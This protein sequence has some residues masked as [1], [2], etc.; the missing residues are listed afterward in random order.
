MK[1]IGEKLFLLSLSA[2]L[3]CLLLFATIQTPV[4][5]EQT[6]PNFLLSAS[7]E[8]PFPGETVSI[9]LLPPFN[10]AEFGVRWEWEGGVDNFI[11]KGHDAAAYEARDSAAKISATVWDRISGED[12]SAASLEI[13]PQSYD[14]TIRIV[15]PENIVQLWDKDSMAMV[16]RRGR[17]SRSRVALGAVIEP[18]PGGELR[19]VWTPGE[20]VVQDSEDGSSYVVYRETPGLAVVSLAVFN[21][22]N[23]RLGGAEISF[24]IDISS[25]EQERSIKLNMGWRRWQ[26][27][28]ALRE[29]GEVEDALV[30]ARQAFEELTAGGMRGDTLRGEMDRFRQ[31]HLNYFRALEQASVAASL[32]RDGKLEE[33]LNQYRQARTLYAHT[34]IER[35]IAEIEEFL[36]RT[37]ERRA[38][39][40]A[41]AQEAQQLADVGDLT[42]AL[43]KYS[44]SLVYYPSMEVRAARSRVEGQRN[45]LMRRIGLA[46]MVRQ[47]GLNLEE[48]GNF[49]E[50]LSKMVE[51]EEIWEL[52]ELATDMERLNSRIAERQRIRSE[53]ATMAREASQMEIA[54]LEGQGD[55]ET[56]TAALDKYRQ[57]R[58]LWRDDSIERAIVRVAIHI[59][60]INSEIEQAEFLA[61][62]ADS[63]MQDNRL[64]EALD[65]YLSAQFLRRDDEVA[66]KIAALE[67]LLETRRQLTREA[68]AHYLRAEEL[69]R[70][71]MLD[72]ALAS[73]LLGEEILISNELA[74]DRFSTTVRRLELAIEARNDRIT[75]AANLAEQGRAEPHP[76]RALDFFLESLNT[77]YT[78]EVSQT[79]RIMRGLLHETRSAEAR[80]AELYREAV[81]LG[82]ES[83]LAEAEEKL[84]SSIAL[85][86][87]SEAEALL[88][89]VREKIA[90]QIWL[91]TLTAQPLTLRAIPVIPRVGER[92]TIRIEG[93]AWTT[94]MSLTYLWS[95]SGNAISDAPLHDGRAFG[96]YPAD[97]EP[98]TVT[99]TVLRAGTDQTLATR[100]ISIM[101]E[102]RTVRV[103]MNEGARVARLWNAATRRLEET[104]QI[105]TGTDIEL[106]VDVIPMPE[107][108]V[109]YSWDADEYSVLTISENPGVNRASVRRISPGTTYVE[110]EA[111]D[112]HGILLGTGRISILVAVDQND[113]ARDLRRYQAW[114]IWAEARELWRAN[115]RLPAIE[116]ATEASVLD[117]GDPDITH[118]LSRMKEELGKME[119]ASRLLA[120]SSLLIATGNLDEAAVR[121]SEADILWPSNKT[122]N[123]RYELMSARE[124]ARTNYVLAA[125]LRAE[126]DALLR[127][128]LRAAALARF[129]DS[130][131]LSE[132][133][134]VRRNVDSLIAEVQAERALIEEIHRLR[135]EGNALV[136]GRHYTEAIERFV[137]SM[138]LRP[139]VYLA[140]YV[141]AL[142]EMA[143]REE[144]FIAEAARLREEGDALMQANNILEALVRYRA[145]LRVRHDE[146]LAI[147]VREEEERIAQARAAELRN[148]AQALLRGRT[149]NPEEALR[150]YRESLRYAHDD[151]AATFVRE[152][153]EAEAVRRFDELMEEGHALVEQRQP[154]QALEVFRRAAAYIP[155]DEELL[156][157][158]RH[159]EL[160]LTPAAP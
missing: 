70:Q 7:P 99:M 121:I 132:N 59:E 91:E 138:H 71:N 15:T 116:R 160:I 123:I 21:Q 48:Q 141:E 63:L 79:I 155:D 153:E 93:G 124:R 157:R 98:I 42:G 114:R 58:E 154:E 113:V 39:A 103:A 130:F 56:L 105:A 29:R 30:Q 32:W 108:A 139:D 125:N 137:L 134:A 115:R 150:L 36:N 57:S 82:R 75:R 88:V 60:R 131:L 101:P 151:A 84:L 25:E 89:E 102:P 158:I 96:F 142:R 55:P 144:L 1:K 106:R 73:A 95:V 12:V 50:A 156:E 136:D 11:V 13:S 100:M 104:N 110:V 44:E 147:R 43:E 41:L 38:R 76:E 135:T 24:E 126:G 47:V 53:A 26:S 27:A 40:A 18:Q 85:N 97:E 112:S 140:S 92:T 81:V 6:E 67:S 10:G 9:L 31:V 133:D 145:S 51:A 35:A 87:T 128:G 37:G 5:A 83:R 49:E 68:E 33:A 152:A 117:P 120:E 46:E 94:D 22:N 127:Q 77:W 69:E 149:P 2:S 45:A 74:T 122:I 80:A 4:A 148:E 52:P 20:G 119:N 118:G 3:I 54:G 14:V 107:S 34:S 61:R 109:F 8:S 66:Q 23:I 62:E 65:R 129:Q 111:R 143:D 64:Y 19:F 86:S 146:S 90:R 17:M 28:L 78:A 159:L 16:D 72:E